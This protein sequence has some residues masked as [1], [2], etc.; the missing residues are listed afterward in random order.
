[1]RIKGTIPVG[2]DILKGPL[3]EKDLKTKAED[4]RISVNVI[5][6]LDDL[7]TDINSLNDIADERVLDQDSV[8]GSLSDIIYTV[9]GHLPAQNKDG[10]ENYNYMRVRGGVIININADVSDIINEEE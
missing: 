2:I 5:F 1:M 3:S 6:S 8:V 7:M 10:S 9:V 4:G